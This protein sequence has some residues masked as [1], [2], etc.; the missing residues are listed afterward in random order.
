MKSK[1]YLI[2]WPNGF[3]GSGGQSWI[4]LD[5]QVLKEQIRRLEK[6]VN[7]IPIDKLSSVDLN[8]D[9]IVIYNSSDNDE[10][11]AYIR[12]IIYFVSKKC[13][14][15][16]SFD[17]LMAHENKGYQELIRQ[18]NGFGNLRSEYFISPHHIDF[19]VPYVLKSVSGAGSSSVW[20]INDKQKEKTFFKKAFHISNVRK[21]KLFHRKLVL[22]PSEYSLYSYR[23]C[24]L[25]R[26]VS[27]EF[28]SDLSG[29]YKVLVFSNKFFVLKRSVRKN[30]FRASGSG[31]FAFETPPTE[32]LE[33]AKCI[34]DK[35]DE[36]YAS[37]DIAISKRGVHLIEYQILNFGPYTLKNSNGYYSL[38]SGKWIFHEGKSDLDKEF[39]R[40]LFEYVNNKNY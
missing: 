18:E 29:D 14:V 8:K 33:Y 28:V 35:L 3:F 22:S 7:I 16:P 4:S 34:F 36:P 19:K 21:V 17:A 9:D 40:A 38:D 25:T 27:Q 10:L 26:Y 2:T 1:I 32:V 12:D 24:G 39:G 31:I 23:H 11:R 13:R 15:V 37:L 5:I 6:E 30:D 20:L